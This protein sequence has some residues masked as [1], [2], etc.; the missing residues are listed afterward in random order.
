MP[1]TQIIGIAI[2]V[3]LFGFAVG[4]CAGT[5]SGGDDHWMITG[6]DVAMNA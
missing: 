6:N 5:R 1:A 3:L 2:A 4:F